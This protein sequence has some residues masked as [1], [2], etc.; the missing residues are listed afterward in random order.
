MLNNK[1]KMKYKDLL[2][3]FIIWIAL[4]IIY[5]FLMM[6]MLWRVVKSKKYE[7]YR[8]FIIFFWSISFLSRIIYF[9]L[10]QAYDADQTF[11]YFL[12]LESTSIGHRFLIVS[13]LLWHAIIGL[14]Y[15]VRWMDQYSLILWNFS[16]YQDQHERSSK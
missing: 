14:T 16:M 12:G 9:S 1:A 6:L 11:N 10:L 2:I 15:S 4:D 8:L 7:V 13:P 5:F 3:V